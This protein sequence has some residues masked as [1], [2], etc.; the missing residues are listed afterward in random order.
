[1]SGGAAVRPVPLPGAV[2]SGGGSR[3][4]ICGIGALPALA[5]LPLAGCLSGPR[6]DIGELRLRARLVGTEAADSAAGQR[7]D[8]RSDPKPA[9]GE[10]EGRAARP[11]ARG[12]AVSALDARRNRILLYGGIGASGESLGDLWELRLVDLS[13]HRLAGSREISESVGPGPRH[14][15]GGAVCLRRHDLFIFCGGASRVNIGGRWTREIRKDAW[16]WPLWRKAA[17]PGAWEILAPTHQWEL[18]LDRVPK[19][20]FCAGAFLD[21]AENRFFLVGGGMDKDGIWRRDPT[22]AIW[23]LPMRPGPWWTAEP[24]GDSAPDLVG[25][26]GA[27]D[28]RRGRYAVFGG[29]IPPREPGSEPEFSRDAYA[30]K[31]S[32]KRWEKIGTSGAVPPPTIGAQ[33]FYL[34]ACDAILLLGGAALDQTGRLMPQ[35]RIFALLLH[36]NRW[37]DVTPDGVQD[38]PPWS[39]AFGTG[40]YDPAA[41]RIVLFGGLRLKPA[42]RYPFEPPESS[43]PSGDTVVIEGL[44]TDK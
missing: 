5:L 9:A 44:P 2:V 34:E 33:A 27:V 43:E 12:M 21:P 37:V 16:A 4:R 8:V 35:K 24:A 32:N 23:T 28:T 40:Q 39:S 22:P 42:A 41:G 18:E 17:D 3:R 26:A 31:L 11:E 10:G 15:A 38:V 19:G 6:C 1:M 7:P 13:W 36:E 30:L 20:K 14:G 25:A 29:A